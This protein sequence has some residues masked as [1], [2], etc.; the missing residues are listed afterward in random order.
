MYI[1]SKA[2]R[3]SSLTYSQINNFF[4]KYMG[5]TDAAVGSIG[6]IN[7]IYNTQYESLID[8][9]SYYFAD[10]SYNR[11]NAMVMSPREKAFTGY[12][13]DKAIGIRVI[14]TLKDTTKISSERMGT[15]T[16]TSRG[17]DYTYN[18]WDLK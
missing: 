1:N 11:A 14:I 12:G 10:C 8:N 16:I 5:Y 18:I 6:D 2:S 9:Y 7:S 15:K 13:S 4:N 3:V 17:T